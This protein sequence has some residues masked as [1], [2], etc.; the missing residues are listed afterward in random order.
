MF[1]LKKLCIK[2]WADKPSPQI[3]YD[4]KEKCF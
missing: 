1:L 3:I 4:Y 2:A